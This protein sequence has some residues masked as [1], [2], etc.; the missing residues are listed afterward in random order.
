MGDDPGARRTWR[1][2]SSAASF[3][4]NGGTRPAC[5]GPRSDPTR[6]GLGRL[7]GLGIPAAVQVTLEVGVFALATTLVGRL[8]PISLAAHQIVLNV[9]SVT[10]MIPLGLSSAAAVRVGPGDRPR[11][12]GR[13][14]RTPAGRRSCSARAS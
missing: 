9:A 8:D 11:R 1:W 10:F 13:P 5:G 3:A 7:V 4:T 2:C 14:P 12:A 6:R